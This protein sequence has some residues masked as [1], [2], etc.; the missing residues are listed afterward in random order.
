MDTLTLLSDASFLSFA[1]Q[2]DMELAEK[3]KIKGCP[4]CGS[5]L[6]FA[7]YQRKGRIGELEVPPE[8][9]SFH[10]L[11]CGTQGCRK[12]VRPLS[13]RFAGQSPFS[14]TLVI[15]AK[16]LSSGGSQRSV[17]ALCKILKTSERTVRRWLSFWKQAQEKSVWWRKLVSQWSLS[18]KSLNNLWG[19]IL[20]N[21]NNFKKSFEY[22]LLSVAELWQE[23]RFNVGCNSPAKDA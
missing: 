3:S 1:Q 19:L 8:W 15:L 7:R 16:L 13:I 23:F 10:S 21:K 14:S 20:K 12:R 11:C 5:K 18:G 22:L 6:Y 9:N 17:H 2:L 4:C